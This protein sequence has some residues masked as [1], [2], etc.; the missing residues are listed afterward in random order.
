M[1][2]LFFPLNFSAFL[3][4]SVDI[5]TEKPVGASQPS[6]RRDGGGSRGGGPFGSRAAP[7]KEATPAPAPAALAI[8][9][10]WWN[11]SGII[12]MHI[13]CDY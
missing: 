11:G 13:A 10:R 9:G 5:K 12:A 1:I 7:E 2:N 3:N 8:R 6:P 4:D